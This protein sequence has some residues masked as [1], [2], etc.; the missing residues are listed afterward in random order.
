MG[1][2]LDRGA[3]RRAEGDRGRRVRLFDPLPDAG[4]HLHER[5]GWAMTRC[6]TAKP[7]RGVR[8]PLPHY[9]FPAMIPM[10]WMIPFAITTGNTFVL[11]AASMVPQ[12]AMRMLELLIEA[13]LPKGVVNLVHLQPGWRPKTLMNESPSSRGSVSSA[14]RTVGIARV[15]DC[16]GRRQTRAMRSPRPR[17]TRWCLKDCVLERAVRGIIN[18]T[19]GCA[20]QRC[21]AL[22]VVCVAKNTIADDFVAVLTKF[23]RELQRRSRPT[24]K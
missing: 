10:G 1:K 22:P 4:R 2:V 21:M 20:A 11:K 19:Y 14:R 18:S 6:P 9:N 3:R 5:V 13:G 8:R 17:T 16:R 24:L 12:T 23:A 7:T 15:Q